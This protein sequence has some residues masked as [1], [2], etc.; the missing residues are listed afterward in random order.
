[1]CH[2]QY[3]FVTRRT[4]MHTFKFGSNICVT[5]TVSTCTYTRLQQHVVCILLKCTHTVFI[6][7][8]VVSNIWVMS[9]IWV[10]SHIRVMS[11]IWVMSQ[12]S[13]ISITW[14]IYSYTYKLDTSN[15]AKG[16]ALGCHN[17]TISHGR[18]CHNGTMS[19]CSLGFLSEQFRVHHPFRS[20]I[21][22][23]IYPPEKKRKG[24]SQWAARGTCTSSVQ[25]M[26]FARKL[27]C[28][29][30]FH[31]WTGTGFF[32]GLQQ[33]QCRETKFVNKIF[34]WTPSS[35]SSGVRKWKID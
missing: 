14:H 5:K 9:H 28:S 15:A 7:I 13:H 10:I 1:M 21:H 24:V 12:L 4:H 26:L 19:H 25:Q 17:G 20:V 30:K 18:G 34:T 31:V 8:R 23:G 2:T 29:W 6:Y 33:E 16:L 11:H 35:N 22:L 27:V 32:W 3:S